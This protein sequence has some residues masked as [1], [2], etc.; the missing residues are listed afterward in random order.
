[1]GTSRSAFLLFSLP[2]DQLLL[3]SA[4]HIRYGFTLQYIVRHTF[5]D[6]CAHSQ[7]RS[8]AKIKYYNS[9]MI[10]SSHNSCTWCA[11]TVAPNTDQY[12]LKYERSTSFFFSPSTTSLSSELMALLTKAP[13]YNHSIFSK[14]NLTTQFIGVPPTTIPHMQALAQVPQ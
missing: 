7:M 12:T 11:Y 4:V 5:F 9:L 6:L 1:M 2:N 13:T 14:S 8:S 10:Y 3:R